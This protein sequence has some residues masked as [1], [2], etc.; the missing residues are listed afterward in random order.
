MIQS[1]TTWLQTL[2]AGLV[3]SVIFLLVFAEDALFF[4]FVLPGETVVI[5][6]GV[7]A[8]QG[9]LELAVLIPLVVVAAI[10][11]DSVGYEVGKHVGP[12]LFEARLLKDRQAGIA[13]ARD[14]L[15]RRGQSAVFL[16]RFTA[17]F[18]AMMPAL[19]GASHMP[20]RRF[21][22]A[23][24]LGGIVWGVATCL[25][26]Y[27]VGTAYEKIA[28]RIGEGLAIAV[29]VA[30][31]AAYIVWRVRRRRAERE[32]ERAADAGDR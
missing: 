17:F 11:G 20:Y 9:H 23:N 32:E 16:G 30:A 13:K 29:A 14:L 19:A 15:A 8:S 26:G 10:V 7:M 24:A 28:S 2:P 21:L 18:R 3:Y 12:R 4:G 31:I 6:G 1:F 25:L 5:L 22:P 27:F